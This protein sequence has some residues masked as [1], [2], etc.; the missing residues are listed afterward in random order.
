M[1][2]YTLSIAFVMRQIYNRKVARGKGR[3]V[4]IS[5]ENVMKFMVYLLMELGKVSW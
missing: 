1:C 3:G 2:S 5:F 4:G